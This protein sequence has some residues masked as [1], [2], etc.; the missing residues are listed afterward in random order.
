MRS[1][2]SRLLAENNLQASSSG[3]RVHSAAGSGS[4]RDD[5]V[6]SCVRACLVNSW[7]ES[8]E[9][10]RAEM[11]CVWDSS[12]QTAGLHECSLQLPGC[13]Y[14]TLALGCGSGS[15][16]GAQRPGLSCQHG[17]CCSGIQ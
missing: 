17:L 1:A 2:L 6:P 12:E 8:S 11:S 14:R 9:Q 5:A 15:D 16:Y 7:N 13:H 3:L 10:T 4:F